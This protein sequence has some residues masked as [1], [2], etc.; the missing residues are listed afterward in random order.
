MKK[1]SI[2]F[3]ALMCLMVLSVFSVC[4]YGTVTTYNFDNIR[5][6]NDTN[7]DIG[8]LQLFVAVSDTPVVWDPITELYIDWYDG[9]TGVI[10]DENGDGLLDGDVLFTF[11]NTGPEQCAI[12]DIYF[13]DGTLIDGTLDVITPDSTEVSF[14]EVDTGPF[15]LPAGL[16]DIGFET[17]E[18]FYANYENG[19]DH[20]LG[21]DPTEWV[22]ILFTLQGDQDYTSVIDDLTDLTLRIGIRVQD[23]D[24]PLPGDS[25]GDEQYV[26]N[27][28]PIPA[29]G[30]ILLGSMG[31]GLV[32]WLRRRK[33]L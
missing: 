24:A 27:S 2:L 4:A 22:S 20:E 13:D 29:P 16:A 33:A 3:T 7:G 9:A 21:V 10:G 1:V 11:Y 8:E 23:F 31:I 14:L 30:A 25:D 19:Y 28:V 17:T 12:T 32:G 18:M 6:W 15:N 26:N 5:N